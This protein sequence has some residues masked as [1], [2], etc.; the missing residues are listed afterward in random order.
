MTVRCTKEVQLGLA[1][2]WPLADVHARS[3]RLAAQFCSVLNTFE[4]FLRACCS[5]RPTHRSVNMDARQQEVRT[6]AGEAPTASS[7]LAMMSIETRFVMQCTSGCSFR[8]F[9]M[10]C[11]VSCGVHIA[12]SR[13]VTLLPAQDELPMTTNTQTPNWS[14]SG[15]STMGSRD[16]KPCSRQRD[17]TFRHELVRV[18]RKK[19]LVVDRA[20]PGGL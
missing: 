10:Y 7:M 20:V 9:D 12:A 18:V 5:L 4:A 6:I 2:P 11:H 17:R 1:K 8:S 19:R 13:G 15:P 16:V 14:H 3:E